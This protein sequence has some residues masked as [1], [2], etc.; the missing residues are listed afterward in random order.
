MSFEIIICKLYGSNFSLIAQTVQAVAMAH[1]HI[2]IYIVTAKQLRY[3]Y[4]TTIFSH[5]CMHGVSLFW[6]EVKQAQR[7]AAAGRSRHKSHGVIP[8]Q[9]SHFS[10]RCLKCIFITPIVLVEKKHTKLIYHKPWLYQ[11]PPL[12]FH[13]TYKN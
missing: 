13:R 8:Y 9:G 11:Y 6:L 2:H 4:F 7:R 3:L 10:T 5:R 1:T 12:P